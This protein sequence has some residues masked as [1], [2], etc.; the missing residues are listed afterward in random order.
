MQPK[1]RFFVPAF[2]TYT[3]LRTNVL[4]LASPS[5]WQ[6]SGIVLAAAIL[7]GYRV[8]HTRDA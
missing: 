4:G 7:A 6:G 2:F 5:D 3:G 1:I 8:E